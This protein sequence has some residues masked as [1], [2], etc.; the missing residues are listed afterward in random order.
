MIKAPSIEGAS[1]SSADVLVLI[2]V[3]ILIGILVL[4][5]VLVGILSAVLVGILVL[6]AVLISVLVIH[7][8]FPPNFVLRCCR[9]HS[10]PRFSG[11]ILGFEN[12]AGE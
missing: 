7:F 10:L 3:R 4:I 8:E 12:Q 5:G 11:F 9:I 6:V 1:V 2:L